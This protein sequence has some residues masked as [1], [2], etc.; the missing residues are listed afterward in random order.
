MK[1][2]EEANHL[3]RKSDLQTPQ[4]WSFTVVLDLSFVSTR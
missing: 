3:F 4:K 1:I 2:P